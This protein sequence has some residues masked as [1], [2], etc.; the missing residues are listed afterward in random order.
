MNKDE[1]AKT[2][3]LQ[4][5]ASPKLKAMI[6]LF[7]QAMDTDQFIDDFYDLIW[8]ISTAETYGLN[9]WGK[10]VNISRYVTVG[11]LDE[12]FGFYEAEA[13]VD[14]NAAVYPL[15]FDEAPFHD[16]EMATTTVELTNEAYRTLIL[17]KAMANIT[18]CTIPDLNK[19]MLYLFGDKGRVFVTDSGDMTITYMFHFNLSD[20]DKSIAISS[21]ALPRP[22]GVLANVIN[23]D[24]DET[25]GFYEADFAPFDQGVFFNENQIAPV[26]LTTH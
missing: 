7:N 5:S 8:N 12:N 14:T 20:V 13:A 2:I 22:S 9:V 10:I 17:A 16:G 6:D 1:L 11:K 23:F 19:I 15:P 26:D 25:F 24:P 3:L 18:D 21:G 4:Y